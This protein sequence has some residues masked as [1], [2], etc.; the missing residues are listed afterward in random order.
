MKTLSNRFWIILLGAILAL[1][2]AFT[3]YV[4]YRASQA[5]EFS[6]TGPVAVVYLDGQMVD[7]VDLGIVEESYTKTY[8][9][10]SGNS[11]TVEFSHGRVRVKSASCPDQVC[12]GQGW[13]K[14]DGI[15]PIACLPNSLIIEVVPYEEDTGSDVDSITK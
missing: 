14:E 15:L 11:N 3:A 13:L 1:C 9:G 4:Y 2:L 12:V 6:I 8:Q 10:S 7:A 5:P